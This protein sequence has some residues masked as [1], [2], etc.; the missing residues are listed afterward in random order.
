MNK[1]LLVVSVILLT[2]SFALAELGTNISI[3]YGWNGTAFVPLKTSADGK[4]QTDMNFTQSIGLNPK[5]NNSYTIGNTAYQWL[6]GYFINGTFSENL[7]TQ[8]LTVRSGLNL[9]ND[10]ITDAMLVNDITIAT[11]NDATI[12]SGWASGG[13]TLYANG[14]VWMNGSL[15]I[16]GNITTVDV[17]NFNV[18][19]YMR[20]AVNNTYDL[21]GANLQ[22]RNFYAV[23][24]NVS[25]NINLA[26]GGGN[27]GIGTTTASGAIGGEKVRVLDSG[28]VAILLE[29]TGTGTPLGFWRANS[30]SPATVDFGTE[31]S[32]DLAIFTASGE[33]VRIDTSGRIGINVTSPQHTLHVN[34]SAN[35]TNRITPGQ[36]NIVINPA[37][38]YTTNGGVNLLITH[39]DPAITLADASAGENDFTIY[40]SNGV[41]GIRNETGTWSATDAY[42]AVIEGGNVGIGTTSPGSEYGFSPALTIQGS[43]SPGIVFNDTN[44]D[45]WS[46]GTSSSNLNIAAGSTER[47]R[48]DSTGNVGIG[49]TA[50]SAKLEINGT[51]NVLKVNGTTLLAISGGNVGIGSASGRRGRQIYLKLLRLVKQEPTSAPILLQ[52]QHL[53][54]YI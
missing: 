48:I 11:T 32:E 49:M 19:G 15:F 24:G 10:A 27:V 46:I 36:R 3:L 47:L 31:G 34:G 7:T 16:T 21:G 39:D 52:I 5:I 8:T 53:G 38:I 12:G 44:G 30:G 18:T 54:F 40:N 43:G 4:L 14:D 45:E 13:T 17:Q 2:S 42:F 6:N 28:D 1:I 29:S 25:G 26:T 33:R 20:P 35:F 50:P 51:G 9:P 22:W 37:A 23:G 41:L